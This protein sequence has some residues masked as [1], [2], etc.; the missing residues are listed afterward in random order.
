[1]K[2]PLHVTTVS[3][4][5]CM[6]TAASWAEPSGFST[7]QVRTGSAFASLPR[8][9]GEDFATA[10]PIPALPYN[11]TGNTCSFQDDINEW[12]WFATD[13]GPDVVYSFVPGSDMT[14][15]FSLCDSTSY[16]S[17]LFLY[18][19][20][21]G[22]LVTCDDDGCG[23]ASVIECFPLQASH[24]YY[25]VVDGYL[26]IVPSRVEW[27]GPYILLVEE[28]GVVSIEPMSW[29]RIRGEYR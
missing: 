27:C 2:T 5:F 25:I 28:C 22:N 8:V 26:D 18:E 9:G 24:T 1:M 16:D 17:I 15:T 4:A 23:I 20:W 6:M 12:C 21:D 10:T 29:G 19:D 7:D 14:V 11:D 3:L 13:T